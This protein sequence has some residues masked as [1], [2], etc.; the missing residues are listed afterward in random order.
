VWSGFRDH[1]LGLGVPERGRKRRLHHSDPNGHA[2]ETIPNKSI[3]AGQTHGK[4]EATLGHLATG[5]S[6]IPAWR[7]KPTAAT[8]H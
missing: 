2:Y 4:H 3:I 6:A 5:A 1:P 8:T 7:V